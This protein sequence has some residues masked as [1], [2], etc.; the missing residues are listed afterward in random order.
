MIEIERKFLLKAMPDI[1]P[2]EIIKI[3]QF[4]FKNKE[5]IW[6]RVRQY[7]S[8]VNGKKWIH[9]IK[10]RI[11]DMSNEEVEKEISKK[12]FDKFKTKCYTNKLNARHIRKER[13]VYPDGDLK[14]EVD[15]FKDNYHLIIAEI[16][17]PS[18]DYELNIPEFINKK[19][20]LEVTGLK[21]FSNRS[22][23]IKLK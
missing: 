13:W 1:L 21:Q 23:S 9:T 15:L 16:E 19:S 2:S 6:E 17:I 18:E 12:E 4:Y 8:N 10:Y 3:D 5:G 22:L 11:N 20:L 7:D 14:W